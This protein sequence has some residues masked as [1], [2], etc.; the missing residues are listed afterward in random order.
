M[1]IY[2]YN[3]CK[4]YVYMINLSISY[5][6]ICIFLNEKIP[7]IKIFRLISGIIVYVFNCFPYFP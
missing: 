7:D 1:V 2:L 4:F 5:C 3:M 6:D